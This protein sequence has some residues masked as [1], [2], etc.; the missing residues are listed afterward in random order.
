MVV[1]V[2]HQEDA[3]DAG[4]KVLF[5]EAVGLVREGGPQGVAEGDEGRLDGD[6]VGVDA[7][8]LREGCGI[9]EGAL[10]G[11]LAG[12]EEP[13]NTVRSERADGERGGEGRVDAAGEAEECAREARLVEV[14]T[15][16]CDECLEGEVDGVG[17][18]QVWGLVEAVEVEGVAGLEE[19]RREL[20]CTAVW[21]HEEAVSVEDELVVRAYLVEVEDGGLELGGGCCEGGASALKL[22]AGEGAC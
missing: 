2:G 6:G 3:A 15:D 8:V 21:E 13:D 10:R 4:L 16:A 17:V 22:A 12:H 11:E 1:C 14:V 7:E 20:F 9:V 19:G 18:G 5:G